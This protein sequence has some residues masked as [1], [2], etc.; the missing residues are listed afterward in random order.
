MG[1][2]IERYKEESEFFQ[3]EFL[4]QIESN[5]FLYKQL[6][7]LHHFIM[8]NSYYIAGG[9]MMMHFNPQ[10]VDKIIYRQKE[11]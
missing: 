8:S 9:S 3:K 7:D 1:K 2:T 6:R 4:N 11:E 10:D 5:Q